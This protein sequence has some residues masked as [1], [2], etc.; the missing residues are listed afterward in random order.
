[1]DGSIVRGVGCAFFGC[2]AIEPG[3]QF[4]HLMTALLRKIGVQF[5]QQGPLGLEFDPKPELL[6]EADGPFRRLIFATHPLL[7]SSNPAWDKNGHFLSWYARANRAATFC[8]EN[9]KFLDIDDRVPALND[10]G[11][12]RLEFLRM[13][14]PH[15]KPLLAYADNVGE[16]ERLT[17]EVIEEGGLTILFWTTYFGR[18][19]IEKHGKEFFQNIPGWRVEE[20]DGGIL[21]TV[22]EFY[23]DFTGEGLNPTLAYLKSKFPKVRPR[24]RG[25]VVLGVGTEF[26]DC[27]AIEA[28]SD[29]NR[30]MFSLFKRLGV[31][32]YKAAPYPPPVDHEPEQKLNASGDIS[33]TFIDVS[34]PLLEPADARWGSDHQFLGSYYSIQPGWFSFG[35][36]VMNGDVPYFDEALHAMAHGRREFLKLMIPYVKPQFALA[37]YTWHTGIKSERIAAAKLSKLFW[38]TYFGPIYVEHHGRAFFENIPAWKVDELEGGFLITVTETFIE[39]V[40]NEPKQLLKYLRQKFKRIRANRFVIDPAF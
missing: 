39:F 16:D 33:G 38:V 19:Y 14:I 9:A 20:L 13:A 17:N 37:D 5:H 27:R 30:S 18:H 26:F 6:F 28:D 21:L 34:H 32:F 36:A 1:M 3:P 23:D 22:T 2:Q 24:G 25:A 12:S 7:E 29:F 40:E 31:V 4:H 11:R 35:G 10:M 8:F 15:V